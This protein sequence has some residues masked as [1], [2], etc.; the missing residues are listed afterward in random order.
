VTPAQLK[1]MLNDRRL[2]ALIDALWREYPGLIN[3][4]YNRDPDK[5][6]LNRIDPE[7]D[8]GIAV[9]LDNSVEGNQS[10]A[11]GT[12]LTA[13]AFRELVVGSFNSLA[14][15]ADS[16]N[17][18]LTDRL[19]AVGNGPD[20]E[21][22][23]IALEILKS[24]LFKLFNAIQVSSYQHGEEI[25]SD[26]IIQ[27]LDKRL[28]LSFDGIWHELALKSDL[29]DPVRIIYQID[30]GFSVGNAIKLTGVTWVKSKADSAAN[31]GTIGIVSQVIDANN[32]RY[33]AG[34]LLPGVYTEGALY[35]LSTV[36]DGELMIVTE[37]TE[38]EIGQVYEFIGTGTAAGLEIEIDLGFVIQSPVIPTSIWDLLGIDRT[39]WA[40]GKVVKFD[41]N[42]NLI[43]GIDLT[44]EGTT[45]IQL[46]DLSATI[47]LAYNSTTGVFS[48]ASGYI[49]PTTQQKANYDS[50]FSWGNHANAGYLTA[51]TKA[52]V[53]SVLTGMISTHD[54]NYDNYQ[55]WIFNVG[56]NYQAVY[57]NNQMTQ[58]TVTMKA[59]L[60]LEVGYTWYYGEHVCTYK[61]NI[62]NLTNIMNPSL[63]H[64]IAI[65]AGGDPSR[66]S[67]DQLKTLIG[68]GGV[69]D[70]GALSG[71]EDDDH[72]QY[73][74]Q[75]RGD[76]RYAQVA[77]SS[78]Q[79]FNAKVLTCSQISNA[80]NFVLSGSD[81]RLK[82]K[83]KKL[84][85]ND[86]IKMDQ[87]EIKQFEYRKCDNR[88][89]YGVI[90]QELEEIAP[91]FVYEGE[92]EGLAGKKL[93][94][95]IDLLLAKVA[96]LEQRIKILEG[97]TNA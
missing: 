86:L 24:G 91:E 4:K 30:H 49:V 39:G 21:H 33:V 20:A 83:I 35:F 72:T 95:Y 61:L 48:I 32:F 73:F 18:I 10:A 85:E 69:T 59:V 76:A 57:S 77:G 79:D 50:A 82:R 52:M 34:G 43:V 6:L 67:L 29:A 84:K 19:L 45:G 14:A 11:I 40:E 96:R 42:G 93:V 64:F 68:G 9:G 23:S 8:F 47:P 89:R 78:T 75:T 62:M 51:I 12:S 65:Q 25:P 66:I 92:G 2:S 28:E 7:T 88:K 31:A 80:T 27:Y 3:E 74:N 53:E 44:G 26:G 41:A 13:Q 46:T 56:G 22:R 38:W 87:I 71:R 94:N 90:A 36:T 5:W 16:G 81:R 17:W 1:K 55:C 58:H 63:S 15:E 97:K 37:S 54:H 60:G 70:H